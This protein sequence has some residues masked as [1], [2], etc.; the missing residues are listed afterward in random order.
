M[1]L[2][3]IGCLIEGYEPLIES[4]TLPDPK[5]R[6]VLAAAI[7]GQASVIVTANIKDF[8]DVELSKWE[9]E[10]VHPDDFVINNI[11][12]DVKLVCQAIREQRESYSRPS[13]TADE[14]LDR[15]FACGLKKST[16]ALRSYVADL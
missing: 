4:L 13:R 1:D 10:A 5:D 12:L 9:I 16:A 14:I 6:H 11:D 8:P 7:K 15:L 2:A 3:V